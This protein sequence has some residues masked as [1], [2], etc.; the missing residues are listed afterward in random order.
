[1]QSADDL[2]EAKNLFAEKPDLVAELSSLMEKI[3]GEGRSTLG[4]ARTNDTP[5]KWKFSM[6]TAAQPK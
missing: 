3:V 2:G 6:R 4:P 1:M 5:I